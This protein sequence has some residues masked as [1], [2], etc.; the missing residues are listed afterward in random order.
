MPQSFTGTERN[1]VD[2]TRCE[3]K[4]GAETISRHRENWRQLANYSHYPHR[5]PAAP[6]YTT[7]VPAHTQHNFKAHSAIVVAA[8]T[9]SL[10]T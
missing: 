2:L 4:Y 1:G 6:A 10:A 9:A 5:S 8:A 7:T 3:K